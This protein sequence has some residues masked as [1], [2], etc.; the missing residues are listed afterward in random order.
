MAVWPTRLPTGRWAAAYTT[1]TIGGIDAVQKEIACM[2]KVTKR[3]RQG[4]KVH[5]G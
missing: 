5:R 1:M 4:V 2:E 3:S